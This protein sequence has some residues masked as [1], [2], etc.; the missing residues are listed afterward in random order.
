MRLTLSRLS[1]GIQSH[2]VLT[3]WYLVTE[4]SPL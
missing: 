3:Y 2:I 4:P 1:H